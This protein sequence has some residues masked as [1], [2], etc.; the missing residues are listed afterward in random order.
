MLLGRYFFVVLISFCFTTKTHSNTPIKSKHTFSIHNN[1]YPSNNSI[2]SP[3][4]CTAL[5][6]PIDGSTNIA[7]NTTLTWAR[8]S[9]AT[10]YKLTIG[11]TFGGNNILNAFDVG[12]S[13]NYT[14]LT[15][16]PEYTNIYV[17]VTPY[18]NDG[19]ALNCTIQTFT[20]GPDIPPPA[21][22]TLINPIPGNINVG[23]RPLITWQPAITASGYK[24][25]ISTTFGGN[26]ILDA[27]DVGNTTSYTLTKDLPN[28]S[29]IYITIT[30]YNLAG[31]AVGCNTDFFSTGAT[32]LR[33][34]CTTI[35]TPKPD[36]KHVPVDT[37][38][39]W[40]TV[41]NADGYII[42]LE[43]LTDGIDVL[44]R[45][46]VGNSTLYNIPGDLPGST[47][48]YVTITP[49]N[50]YGETEDC[51]EQTFT[52]GLEDVYPP[53]NFFTPNGD[54]FND[55]W[56]VP[57]P[58]NRIKTVYIFNRYGKL[59]KQLDDPLTGWNGTYKGIPLPNDD[60]WYRIVYNDGKYTTGYFSLVR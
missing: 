15:K 41:P 30:P 45:F 51:P 26:D 57:N 44:N 46:D 58:I 25:T 16:L 53:P 60:Y 32:S 5:S 42:T 39:I 52:T 49:Y 43:T 54:G 55:I 9:N 34:S 2:I 36:A 56:I 10:G 17:R 59:L 33:P 1:S 38:L 29:S 37:D 35:T 48:M 13:A 22:S 6:Y 47:T 12:N 27:E 7:V 8:V 24:L 23:I 21:C 20:T 11:T 19:D 40:N 28:G 4:L 18:N 14:F 31:D 50:I 3:P